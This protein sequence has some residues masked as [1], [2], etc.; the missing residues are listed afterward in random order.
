[1]EYEGYHR[2]QSREGKERTIEVF[3]VGQQVGL[4]GT[5]AQAAGWYWWPCFPG[6]LPDGEAHGPYETALEAYQAAGG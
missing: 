5:A 6:G 2:I 3:Y 1:M 4:L